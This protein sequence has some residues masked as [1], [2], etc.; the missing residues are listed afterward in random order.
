MTAKPRL[1]EN[2]GKG[3]ADG[4]SPTPPSKGRQGALVLG[5]LTSAMLLGLGG[6]KLLTLGQESTDNAQ[7]EADVV[8]VH[9]R[10]AGQVLRVRVADNSHVSQGD[11]LVELDPADLTLAEQ[12]AEAELESA[13][14]QA[15]AAQ[16]QVTVAEAGARGGHSTARAQVSASA[17]EVSRAESGVAVARAQ[18]AR[19]EADAGRANVELERVAT[20]K[21]DGALSQAEL[22][23]AHAAQ[24]S[25]QAAL[26]AARAQLASAE[27]ARLAATSHVAE[28]QGQLDQS[29]PVDAKIAVARASAALAQARMRSAEATL[30]QARLQVA[31]TRILAPADGVVSRLGSRVGQLVS[32]GQAVAQLVPT[33]TYVVA[34][35]KETQVGHMREGQRAE[36]TVDAFSGRKLVGRVESLSGGTGARFALLPPDNASGN[37]VKVV[38]RVPV[39]IAWDAAPEDLRLRAGLSVEVTVFTDSATPPASPPREARGVSATTPP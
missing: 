36:V 22:D 15:D 34:N 27:Q 28:A 6:Y 17:A 38:Q 5:V 16:A 20:L 26:D 3:T 31:R 29:A 9:A 1:V 39:R 14:A 23:D 25:A 35:F 19:A 2:E 33:R 24:A 37:F 21:S 10:V 13:R 18:L 4:A 8:P 32:A 11:V 7:V 12:Q 30:A